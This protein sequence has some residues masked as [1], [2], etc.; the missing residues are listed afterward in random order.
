MCI[1]DRGA[2]GRASS[3]VDAFDASGYQAVHGRLLACLGAV[4]LVEP[5]LAVLALDPVLDALEQGGAPAI[6]PVSW[7]AGLTNAAF[8][9]AASSGAPSTWENAA[10][11][12]LLGGFGIEDLLVSSPLVRPPVT[13][14]PVKL[15]NR[16]I[17][18]ND[19]DSPTI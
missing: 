7:M 19:P 15:G 10:Y 14:A 2:G 12:R 16:Y 11:A 1:R 13:V 3:A 4:A 6:L 18:A 9:G 8:V 17:L 5:P